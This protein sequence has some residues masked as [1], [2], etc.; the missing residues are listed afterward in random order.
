MRR[1]QDNHLRSHIPTEEF[2]HIHM[3]AHTHANWLISCVTVLTKIRNCQHACLVKTELC[4][5]KLILFFPSS[6]YERS[7]RAR[8]VLTLDIKNMKNCGRII[9]YRNTENKRRYFIYLKILT[10]NLMLCSLCNSKHRK[11]TYM[12]FE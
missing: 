11:T 2:S 8:T 1:F 6:K 9:S 3:R 5:L 12:G 4:F 7:C 10:W